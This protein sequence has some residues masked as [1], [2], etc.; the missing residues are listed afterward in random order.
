MLI[1][2]FPCPLPV[3]GLLGI[4]QL[5]RL[6]TSHYIQLSSGYFQLTRSSSL[7]NLNRNLDPIFLWELSERERKPK[8]FEWLICYFYFPKKKVHL[9]SDLGIELPPG[10]CLSRQKPHTDFWLHDAWNTPS[11]SAIAPHQLLLRPRSPAPEEELPA[12]MEAGYT[13][14]Q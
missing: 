4:A 11:L 9:Y 3:R 2:T 8:Y 5:L 6:S 14:P 10:F 12:T 1:F 13:A 7:G